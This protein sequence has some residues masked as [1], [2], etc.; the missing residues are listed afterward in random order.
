MFGFLKSKPKSSD[1]GNINSEDIKPARRTTS[2]PMLVT[3]D[4]NDNAGKKRRGSSTRTSPEPRDR[5]SKNDFDESRGGLENQTMEQLETYAVKK[6]EETTSSV[7]NCL[8]MAENI[9]E[10]ATKTLDMLHQQGE[11][12]NKTHN[13]T[14]DT[15]KDL[16]KVTL[17]LFCERWICILFFFKSWH[18]D[19]GFYGDN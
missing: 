7:N 8:R 6:A 15:D 16:T 1:N 10:D 19:R 2:E 5:S 13:M 12:I 14:V 4:L 18:V 17:L 9:R 3:P 11:Q